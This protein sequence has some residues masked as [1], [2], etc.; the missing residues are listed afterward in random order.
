MG[1]SREEAAGCLRLTLSEFTTGA[2]IDYTVDK[3]KEVVERLRAAQRD[4]R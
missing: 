2:E 3:L 4:V 1:R